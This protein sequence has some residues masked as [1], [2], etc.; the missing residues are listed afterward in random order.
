M[1]LDIIVVMIYTAGMLGLGWYGM[2]LSL[3][4]I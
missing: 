3:I 1:A 4:H 2:R